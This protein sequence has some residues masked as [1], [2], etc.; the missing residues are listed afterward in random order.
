MTS[1]ELFMKENKPNGNGRHKR[2]EAEVLEL[3]VANSSAKKIK[4]FLDSQYIAP[5]SI[6]TVRRYIR[7]LKQDYKIDSIKASDEVC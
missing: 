2:F 1:L 3:L 7:Q 5:V 4:E 6:N